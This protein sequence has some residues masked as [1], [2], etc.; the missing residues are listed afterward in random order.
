M[1]AVSKSFWEPAPA[2]AGETV[3][4][5]GGGPS[6]EFFDWAPFHHLNI[7]GCNDAYL[8]GPWVDICYFGDKIWYEKHQHRAA[9]KRY[10][11]I[12]MGA[13]AP[14]VPMIELMEADDEVFWIERRGQGF[15]TDRS[16][17]WLA[18]NGCTGAGA[19]NLAYLLGAKAVVL[20][21]FD[22]KLSVTGES[23]WHREN[24]PDPN[25][26]PN[27]F[28]PLFRTLAGHIEEKAPDFKVFNAGPDSVLDVFPFIRLFD[29]QHR[30]IM[31]E[32]I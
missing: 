26:Y 10:D 29:E 2:W 14:T 7:I 13:P 28:I 19:I 20:L 21:G 8:L 15:N 31:Q 4:I 1:I 11:G 24:V 18:A 17:G 6:L 5:I 27:K 23:N 3:I 32:A 25:V 22:M 9:W 30:D 12:K 16:K